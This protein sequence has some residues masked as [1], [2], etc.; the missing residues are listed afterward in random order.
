MISCNIVG[1]LGNQLFQIFTT[2]AHS[3]KKNID[4]VFPVNKT[5]IDDK[6]VTY[7][8][9][10]FNELKTIEKLPVLKI[11][12][13]LSFKYRPIDQISDIKLCGWFQSYK[14]FEKEYQSIFKLCKL[15][16]KRL[17]CLD[18]YKYPYDNCISIHFRIY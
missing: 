14:Y 5:Q 12:N 10:I 16:Q 7:W 13:E 17:L 15:D 1:G 6:R 9:N 11:Y 3:V 8:D 18:K 2:I 4:Y